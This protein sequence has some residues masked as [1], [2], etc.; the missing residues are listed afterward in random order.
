MHTHEVGAVVIV[1]LACLLVLR[2]V[3]WSGAV[4][5]CSSGHMPHCCC[6]ATS[7]SKSFGNHTLTI[8]TFSFSFWHRSL[9]PR[10]TIIGLGT[11]KT[12]LLLLLALLLSLLQ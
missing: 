11:A 9:P 5:N 6:G 2:G 1:V 4:Y 3:E 7:T 8:S 12:A 10:Q